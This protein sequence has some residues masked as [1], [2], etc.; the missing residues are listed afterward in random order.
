MN[1]EF[2]FATAKQIYR[3]MVPLRRKPLTL[4][5]RLNAAHS[6]FN[7]DSLWWLVLPAGGAALV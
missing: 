6:D 3:I 5:D 1:D 4:L 7:I 2:Y